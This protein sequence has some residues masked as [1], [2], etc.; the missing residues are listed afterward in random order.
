MGNKITNKK[1]SIL[2][3]LVFIFAS[4]LITFV[5]HQSTI[6]IN[7]RNNARYENEMLENG[8]LYKS[9]LDYKKKMSSDAGNFSI[10]DFEIVMGPQELEQYLRKFNPDFHNYAYGQYNPPK[11]TY[12]SQKK[13]RANLNLHSLISDGN[14]NVKNILNEAAEY[15]DELAKDHPNQ[16]YIIAITDV[17]DISSCKYIIK[18]IK[19]DKDKYKNLRIV[20]GVEIPTTLEANNFVKQNTKVN[21]LALCIN[22]FD[23]KMKK[24]FSNSLLGSIEP[25]E[26]DFDS[27]ISFLNSQDFLIYG[28]SKPLQ[29]EFSSSRQSLVYIESLLNYYISN[30]PKTIKFVEAYYDPYIYF[31]TFESSFLLE[32]TE[33]LNLYR[34]GSLELFGDSIFN[35]Y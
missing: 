14:M 1:F 8:Y 32:A 24:E 9:D 35:T 3:I 4:C 27:M 18:T 10:K 2:P 5:N 7:N 28:I 20:F 30:N 16:K 29:N 19:A 12:L 34:I 22:P 6:N 17:N 21:I 11:G 25:K 26:R 31:K 15:A 13:L 23:K 33:I